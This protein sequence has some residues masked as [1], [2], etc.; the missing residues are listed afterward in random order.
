MKNS[1][2]LNKLSAP[3]VLVVL[4][5]PLELTGSGIVARNIIKECA[6]EGG[7]TML[8]TAHFEKKPNAELGIPESV[9]VDTVLFSGGSAATFR[10]LSPYSRRAD[11][12]SPTHA[13]PN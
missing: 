9:S 2:L 12:G 6:R 10:F 11:S 8:L 13:L 3:R 5:V 7:E 4:G 1:D